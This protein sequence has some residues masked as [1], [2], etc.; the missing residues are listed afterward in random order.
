VYH[1]Y[2]STFSLTTKHNKSCICL[3]SQG[4]HAGCRPGRCACGRVR[5]CGTMDS[6]IH[7]PNTA[8]RGWNIKWPRA[9]YITLVFA[10][11][12]MCGSLVNTN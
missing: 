9:V 4:A 2:I 7:Y 1:V 11:S 5:S 12:I 3:L 6:Q 10:E 8:T